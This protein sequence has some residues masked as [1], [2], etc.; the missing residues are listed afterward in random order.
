MINKTK[1]L[2]FSFLIIIISCVNQD[3]S[4]KKV[5]KPLQRQN[6]EE[7]I[8]PYYYY[9]EAELMK[10]KGEWD[11]YLENLKKVVEKDDKIFLH[12]ELVRAL[13]HNK[14]YNEALTV[15]KKIIEVNK[16]DIEGL[17]LIANVYQSLDQNLEAIKSYEK[18]LLIK[19]DM[20]NVYLIVAD[21]YIKEQNIPMAVKTYNNLIQNIPDSYTGYFY[22]G[23]LMHSQKKNKEAEKNFL[24]AAELEPELDLT[25]YNLIQV[26]IDMG[27]DEKIVSIYEKIIANNPK[28][29]RALLHLGCYYFDKKKFKKA[30]EIFITLGKKAQDH[31]LI[32]KQLAGFF[33]EQ[34]NMKLH[35]LFLKQYQ[36]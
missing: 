21:M 22:L 25:Y 2:L 19:K 8:S 24:K 7:E 10:N 11:K 35:L 12:K 15:L 30:N 31:P 26:Y 20:V 14:K 17:V 18:I 28:D 36:K 27:L 32:V 4:I 34:K 23:K 6:F 9:L 33:F 29:L 3:V 16:E 13:I 5:Q 1:P